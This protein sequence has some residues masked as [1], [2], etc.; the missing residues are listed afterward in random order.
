[1]RELVEKEGGKLA[2]KVDEERGTKNE[3][4]WIR[5]SLIGLD[6]GDQTFV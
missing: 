6:D 3:Q 4:G 1:M 2:L 5:S